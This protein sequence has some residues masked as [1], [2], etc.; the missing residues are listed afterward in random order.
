[1]TSL[2]NQHYTHYFIDQ[3][4]ITYDVFYRIFGAH[5]LSAHFSSTVVVAQWSVC[6]VSYSAHLVYQAQQQTIK[7][8]D[9]T[10]LWKYFT[11]AKFEKP[12]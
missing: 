3:H 4:I 9:N 2:V 12:V 6:F 5:N 11:T 1:M 10:L 7:L 8:P